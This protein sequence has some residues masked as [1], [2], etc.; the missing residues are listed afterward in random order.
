MV[1]DLQSTLS[2]LVLIDSFT[3]KDYVVL[4]IIVVVTLCGRRHFVQRVKYLTYTKEER[5]NWK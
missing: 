5:F 3:C 1:I 4:P 2:H